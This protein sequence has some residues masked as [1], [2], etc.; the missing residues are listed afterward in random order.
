MTTHKRT[1]CKQD[2]SG[3]IL[4][5]MKLTIRRTHMHIKPKPKAIP[6]GAARTSHIS[7]YIIVHNYCTPYS[8]KLCNLSPILLIATTD[9]LK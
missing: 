4:T 9:Y 6:E 2:D 5:A 8:T 1:A 7:V 3:T